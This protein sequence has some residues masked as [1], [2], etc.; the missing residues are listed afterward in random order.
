MKKVVRNMT[1]TLAFAIIAALGLLAFIRLAPSDPAVWHVSPVTAAE[2][3]QGRC[4]NA[5]I[6]QPNGARAACISTDTP[7]SLLSRLDQIALATPRTTRLAGS[8]Q[9][10]RITWITRTALI[11]YPDYT[12]AEASQTPTGTRLDIHARQR[13]GS[14]DFGVNTAR[15]AVWLK[16]F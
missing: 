1:M 8:P 7:E 4:A 12:T 3:G 2:A 6:T 10:G 14:A 11:G 13:F 5:I 16:E 15:L 9:S